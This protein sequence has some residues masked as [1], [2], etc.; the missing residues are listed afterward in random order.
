M[1]NF[2][3]FFAPFSISNYF[4]LLLDLQRLSY[5]QHNFHCISDHKITRRCEAEDFQCLVPK[6]NHIVTSVKN[7][8]GTTTLLAQWSFTHNNHDFFFENP[9]VWFLVN[10][11][12]LY[13]TT[14]MRCNWRKIFWIVSFVSAKFQNIVESKKDWASLLNY[15]KM[16]LFNEYSPSY[17]PYK[18]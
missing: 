15:W 4:Q 10:L 8:F 5:F 12:K 9:C 14:K 16:N 6:K 3:V 2:P 13:L 18:P 7:F 11:D 1:R 17:E